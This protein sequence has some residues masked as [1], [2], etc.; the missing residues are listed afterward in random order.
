MNYPIRPARVANFQQDANAG[1]AIDPSD[2]DSELN[3]LVESLDQTQ[4]F[5]RGITTASGALKNLATATAQALAG[6]QRFVATASQTQFN[7][8]ITW[9]A[10]F[11]NLNVEVFSQGVKLDPNLV[12]VANNAGS[13][14]VTIPAQ[15]LS[16][17][18]VVNAFESG[19]GVLTRLATTGSG[20]DGANMV[21]IQDAGARIT[22]TT[23]E[24]ALQEIAL[25]LSTFIAS[26]GTIANY[27]KKDGS[28]VPTANIPMGSF[29]IT[30]LAD[31]TASTDAATVGQVSAASATLATLA[32]SFIKRDGTN[33]PSAD[34]S[35][36]SKKI[37]SLATPTASGDATNKSYVDGLLT[38]A[39]PTGFIGMWPTSTPPTGWLLCNGAAVSRTTYSALSTLLNSEGYVYG[40]G[41]GATTFN[42]P[43]YMGRS[44]LGAGTGA[45]KNAS[46]TGVITGGTAMTARALGAWGGE[47]THVQTTAELVTHNHSMKSSFES[48]TTGNGMAGSSYS[49]AGNNTT[50]MET[51][52]TSSAMPWMH[53]F[54]VVNFIIKT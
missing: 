53:P 19:A 14:R 43:N 23:V 17:V 38:T 54:T 16:N 31:G 18:V 3:N 42:V 20:S 24:G 4:D 50:V 9:V 36:N 46:G 30:G 11:T 37:T 13:L 52:G 34:T 45:Q 8:S 41:D 28:V 21:G 29:K 12:T 49:G 39:A 26:V 48:G 2:L 6:S 47:E 5:V 10:A 44:P 35:W 33:S 7:T 40:A 22:A 25:N 27:L 51:S 15:T 1:V 32:N